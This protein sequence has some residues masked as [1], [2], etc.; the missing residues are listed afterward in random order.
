MLDTT[1]ILGMY[2]CM[3]LFTNDDD[4]ADAWATQTLRTSPH[5]PS[6]VERDTRGQRPGAPA[7]SGCE[8]TDWAK[9]RR[10]RAP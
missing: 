3:L 6:S 5:R 2:M 10:Q 9:L 4:N 8:G 1:W 7:R